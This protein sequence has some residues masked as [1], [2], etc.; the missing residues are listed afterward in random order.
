MSAVRN[1]AN[2]NRT[3]I[4]TIHQPSAETFALFDTLLLLAAG[5]IIYF[6]STS[7]MIKYFTDSPFQ[8]NYDE[9]SNPA[10]F[11]V[12]VAGSFIN[13]CDGRK[14][15]GAELVN[16]FT[17]TEQYSAMIE[18][19]L[20]QNNPP[21]I[22]KTDE[23]EGEIDPNVVRYNTSTYHQCM[24]LIERRVKV[25][26][27]DNEP[28]VAQLVRLKYKYIIII[29]VII[30]TSIFI[31]IIYIIITNSLVCFLYLY[32]RNIVLGLLYGSIFFQLATGGDQSC[33]TNRMALFFFGIM[34][35]LMFHLDTV[36]I[37][38]NE[39]LLFYRE[40]G[41]KAYGAFSYWFSLSIPIL[42][43]NLVILPFQTILMYF[44]AGLRDGHF[45]NYFLILLLA[46]YIGFFVNCLS[47]SISSS[48][49]VALSLIPAIVLFN[50]FYAGFIVYIPNLAG[51]E[52]RWVPYIVFYRY[53]FQGL[54]LNEFKDND[55][56]TRADGYLDSLD[57]NDNFSM[58]DC[59][60]IVLAYL[61]FF[62]I[63]FYVA[64]RFIDF[65][66]R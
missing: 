51:F 43:F 60:A 4:C 52:G 28:Q 11:V 53:V 61:V 23:D 64:L 27:R 47:A 55:D 44:M 66:Q 2:Q 46:N 63:A 48:T 45:G 22:I 42:V 14:I 8:F 1:L 41:A 25:M 31:I 40:R 18:A 13:A 6:G 3:V 62:A 19:A 38:L 33:Y 24:I 54:V 10:D 49:Q 7:H 34:D 58:G 36:G 16:Y 20:E 5:K 57:F 39:R 32:Y 26:L 50:A 9:G 29:I 65:E 15:S 12:A 59:V 21:I 30:I 56:L 17:T 37:V 35:Q